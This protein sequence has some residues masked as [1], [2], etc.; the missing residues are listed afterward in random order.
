MLHVGKPRTKTCLEVDLSVFEVFWT[1]LKLIQ[2]KIQKHISC[3]R[4]NSKFVK[5][6][7]TKRRL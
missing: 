2:V 7:W 5:L 4:K 3:K 1:L 6:N